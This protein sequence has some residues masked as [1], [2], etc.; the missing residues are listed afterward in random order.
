MRLV[1][2]YIYTYIHIYIY[3]YI[4]IYIYIHGMYSFIVHTNSIAFR[5]ERKFVTKESSLRKK[6]KERATYKQSSEN[7]QHV[8]PI[9]LV[10]TSSCRGTI[11]AITACPAHR[12]ATL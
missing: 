10:S 11:L 2:V 4:H 5:Y 3:T 6:R 9:P 7:G 12:A 1:L 8:K